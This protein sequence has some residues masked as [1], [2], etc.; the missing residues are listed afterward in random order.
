MI[1]ITDKYYLDSDSRNYIL[2]EKTIV[3]NEESKAFGEE[4]YTDCGFYASLESAIKGLVTISTREYIAKKSLNSIEE[5][6]KEI[7]D[8]RKFIEDLNLSL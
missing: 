7:K 1:K 8:L 6:L 5:L 4:R 2:R 3:T